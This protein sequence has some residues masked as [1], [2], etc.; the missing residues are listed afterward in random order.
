MQFVDIV[1]IDTAS[2]DVD[3]PGGANIGY[4]SEYDYSLDVTFSPT[5]L[6]DITSKPVEKSWIGLFCNGRRGRWV[7]RGSSC[8]LEAL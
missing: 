2:E 6:Q 3:H 5:W 8:V 4:V 7:R 1:S